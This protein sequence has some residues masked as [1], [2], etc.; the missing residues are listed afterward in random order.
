[1][2]TR[3][4]PWQE[5]EALSRQLDQLF[6]DI[7]P[8]N[9][10]ARTWGPAIELQQTETDVVLRAELPGIDAKD[11]DVQVARDAVLIKGEYRTET[12]TDD[13]NVVRSEFRYGNFHRTIALPVEVQNDQVTADF[14]NGILTLTLPKLTSDRVVKLNLGGE[15]AQAI[16]PDT[17]SEAP[18]DKQAEDV[19]AE[20]AQ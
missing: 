20:D 15:E 13:K 7:T 9:R 6:N 11:L 12:K 17:A 16:A 18:A 5:M 4:Q 3:W 8:T 10:T 14:N 2:L 1:M 19:W